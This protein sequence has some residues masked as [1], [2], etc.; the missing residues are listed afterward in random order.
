MFASVLNGFN[1]VED[2]ILLLWKKFCP[3][4]P[5]FMSYLVHGLAFGTPKFYIAP[6][7]KINHGLLYLSYNCDVK[8]G[9]RVEP[10]S[11]I[12]FKVSFERL[13]EPEIEDAILRLIA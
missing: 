12:Q 6:H 10:H 5:N 2:K 3:L 11:G 9:L 13:A 7:G 4:R 8:S 1:S